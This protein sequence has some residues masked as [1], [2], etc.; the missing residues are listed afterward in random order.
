MRLATEIAG[1]ELGALSTER[2]AFYARLG[3]EIWQGP[4]AVRTPAGLELT[5]FDDP[6]DRVMILRTPRTPPLDPTATLI[7]EPRTL[8][9]W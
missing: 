4:L 7:G 6:N 1:F 8:A 9:H 2:H 3:W 5:A